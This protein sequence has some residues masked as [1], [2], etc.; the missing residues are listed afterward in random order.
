MRCGACSTGSRPSSNPSAR[1]WEPTERRRAAEYLTGLLSA[2][3][4]QDRR[5]DRLSARPGSPADADVHRPG[6]LGPS[7]P[8][9]RSSPSRSGSGSA[10]PDGVI[11]FDPSAFAKK[12]D[13]SVGVARQW[14][15]RLGKVENCQVGVY[16]GYVSP[17]R[18]CPGQLPA[19]SSPR[20][21]RRTGPGAREA[22]V[23]RGGPVPD[24]P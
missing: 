16:M 7:T 1:R 23:P 9:W 4:A 19:L 18:T 5:G 17:D 6:R 12:G 13:K 15:G 24:P 21:G 22:G 11:V 8:R 20:S 2:T 10:Q 3:G 14:C